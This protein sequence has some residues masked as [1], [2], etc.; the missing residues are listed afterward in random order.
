M[1]KRRHLIQ[2]ISP[3]QR[4]PRARYYT[5]TPAPKIAEY[6][7][8]SSERENRKSKRGILAFGA[9][10]LVVASSGAFLFIKTPSATVSNAVATTPKVQAAAVEEPD[11]IDYSSIESQINGIIAQ[12]P[13]LQISV[14]YTDIKTTTTV[15]TG[16]EEPYIAAS[17]A[18]LLTAILYL[19]GVQ[20]GKYTLNTKVGGLAAE[21]QLRKMIEL[22]D[23]PSWDAFNKLLTKTAL[24]K[25]ARDTG[26]LNYKYETNT[27]T[28]S[29]IALLLE[30]LYK[31]QLLNQEN[32]QLLLSY[33]RHA[34][35]SQYI[36][37][38]LPPDVKVF[39]K[40]G[41]LKDRAHDAAIVDDGKSPFVLVIFTKSSGAY[42]F[43]V[44][45][46][47]MHDITKVVLTVYNP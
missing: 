5:P 12:Y 46:K 11:P 2:D 29:D 47:I 33:M 31:N 6:T 1:E 32:T 19:Q 30:K 7:P 26:L 23:N 40:A 37:A 14:A 27:S 3:P 8:R 34:S 38:A 25:F 24:N 18:K 17:T 36:P 10:G 15:K 13:A 35:E 42:D 43:E 22:S 4:V 39:H 44:G 16:V 41:Y 20:Q 28:P 21:G 9:L 45:K